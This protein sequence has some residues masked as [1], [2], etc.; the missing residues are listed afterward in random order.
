MDTDPL[1]SLILSE[2]FLTQ[3]A[4]MWQALHNLL[5]LDLSFL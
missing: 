2:R 5:H 4:E 1:D 3:N